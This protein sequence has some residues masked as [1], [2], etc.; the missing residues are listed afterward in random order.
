VKKIAREPK[1]GSDRIS[2]ERKEE[3]DRIPEGMKGG[4]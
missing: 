2:K 1:E 4:G 3:T